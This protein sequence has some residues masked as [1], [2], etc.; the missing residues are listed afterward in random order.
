MRRHLLVAALIAASL[1]FKAAAA[2]EDR[3]DATLQRQSVEAVLRLLKDKYVFPDVAGKIDATVRSKM[4]EGT[5]D[6]L[7]G[8]ALAGALTHDLRAVSHDLH[9]SVQYSNELLP[10][11]ETDSPM[12]PPTKAQL[13]EVKRGLEPMKYGVERVDVLDGNVG[14]LRIDL[15]TPPSLAE[16]TYTA[17]MNFLAQTDALIID[18]RNNGG[19][20]DPEAVPLLCSYFFD[21][22]VHLNDFYWKEGNRTQELWTRA[23]VAGKKYLDKPIYVLIGRHTFSGAEEFAYDLK[24]LKRATLVGEPTGGGANPGG[25]RRADDH[26]TVWVP[27]GRAIN[28]ISKT[29]WEGTGVSP[30]VAVPVTKALVTSHLAALQHTLAKRPEW[31]EPVKGSISKFEKELAHFKTVRFE[32]PGHDDAREV[33]VAGTFNDWSDSSHRLERRG[34]SWSIEI[35]L[36]PGRIEYKFV[37]DGKW[38]PD[39][40]RPV[41]SSGD[42]TADANSERM[43][44]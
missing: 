6:T 33:R 44:E 1:G 28:P 14:Y 24:N 3:P 23:E 27:V 8:P 42:P 38:I 31:A 22:P 11:D 43:V 17:A 34:D 7:D 13:E 36:A 35:P 5:Y 26:F 15:F 9:L 18:L 41:T 30:D 19:S 21:K 10:P 29:N 39:P 32:L 20:I 16:D 4:A 37:M 2:S 25:T 40:S 12:A